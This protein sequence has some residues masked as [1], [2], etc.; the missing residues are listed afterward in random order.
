MLKGGFMYKGLAIIFGFLF[1]G[2]LIESLGIPVL[3][4]VLGMLLLTI[5]LITGIIEIRDVEKEAEFLVKNMS[6]MFIPPGVGIILYLDLLKE[7]IVA[8]VTALIFS[9]LI[10]L[11]ATGKVVEVLRR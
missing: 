9:F 7:N 10:T 8:I 4:S 1:L 5:A 2:E 6:I 11:W 3:G